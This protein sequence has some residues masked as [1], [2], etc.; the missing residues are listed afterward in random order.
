[1]TDSPAKA[2]DQQP[3][4]YSIYTLEAVPPG[5]TNNNEWEK[6]STTEDMD[7]SMAD[8]QQLFSSD[9]YQKV[10]VK[11]K[12]FEEKTGRTIEMTLRLFEAKE[13]KDRSVMLMVLLAVGS[14]VAAFALTFFLT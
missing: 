3:I 12:Y 4:E 13:K 9:I 8:A 7:K 5:Q 6:V 14:G 11:K 10:E 1:M 2:D